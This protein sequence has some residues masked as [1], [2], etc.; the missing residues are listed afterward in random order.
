MLLWSLPK[1]IHLS[2]SKRLRK[3]SFKL[4]LQTL[5]YYIPLRRGFSNIPQKTGQEC[6][7]E[8]RKFVICNILEWLF[9]EI[10]QFNLTPCALRSSRSCSLR[11]NSLFQVNGLAFWWILHSSCS[12]LNHNE[13]V[14]AFPPVTPP[15]MLFILFPTYIQ[16]ELF[17][18]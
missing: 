5:T 9:F 8:T 10:K 3:I 1:F 13:P 14:A 16:P 6:N 17:Q 4:E 7:L 15:F 2:L 12:L 11:I 18:I